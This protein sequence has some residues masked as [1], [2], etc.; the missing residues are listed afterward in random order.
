MR[1]HERPAS[2]QPLAVQPNGQPAVLLLLEELVRAAVPDLD[3]ARAV[4]AL[5]DLAL[6]LRVLE[7]VVLDVDG[8]VLLARLERHALRHRPAKRARRCVSSRKS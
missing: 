6:E 2:L 4:L 5:R 3:R 8:E 7:R 1:R